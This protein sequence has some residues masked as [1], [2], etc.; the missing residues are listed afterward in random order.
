MSGG[1]PTEKYD[2]G[3]TTKQTG[4][5]GSGLWIFTRDA[6]PAEGMVDAARSA[7]TELG[8]TLSQLKDVEQ[9]GCTYPGAFLKQD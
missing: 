7:L 5:N 4:T 9:A 6:T 1:P 2:D 3:C 8:Y